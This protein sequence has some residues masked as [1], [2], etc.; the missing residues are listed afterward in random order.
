[1][2]KIFALLAVLLVAT[3]ISWAQKKQK[4]FTQKQ[5]LQALQHHYKAILK[6]ADNKFCGNANDFAFVPLGTNPCGGA[7]EYLI[8][9]KN[10]DRKHFFQL[11]EQYN[12]AEA[13]Y[14]QKYNIQG[15]CVVLETPTN[16][17]CVNK[18]PVLVY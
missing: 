13:S 5:H 10:I 4:G 14:N 12:Q 2:K 17:N 18:K 11:V 9:S 6:M 1:M 3:Q 8:Y 15:A 7:K 16:I